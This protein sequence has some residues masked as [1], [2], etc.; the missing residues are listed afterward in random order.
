VLI[1]CVIS[2]SLANNSLL[3]D[4]LGISSDDFLGE[5]FCFF[6]VDFL[7]FLASSGLSLELSL[8]VEL[9][10]GGLTLCA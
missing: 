8:I 1:A 9:R 4:L 5:D 3:S 2:C 10:G 7:L 6:L